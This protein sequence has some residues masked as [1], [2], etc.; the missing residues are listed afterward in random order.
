[1]ATERLQKILAAAGLAS[2]R[3][4]EGII[5]DGR[6]TVNGR[7]VHALPVLVDP[8]VDEIAVD[9]RPLRADSDFA[10]GVHCDGEHCAPTR[11]GGNGQS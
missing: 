7:R 5:L 3:G 11:L 8:E 1:M 10:S 9:G 6:V 2:R 4:C